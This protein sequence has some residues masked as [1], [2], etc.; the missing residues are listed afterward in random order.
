MLICPG[1]SGKYQ[2]RMRKVT[3]P[4]ISRDTC[5]TLFRNTRLGFGF[6]LDESF[7]CA[8]GQENLDTCTGDGGGPL[9]CRTPSGTYV[10]AG[11]TSWGIGCGGKDVPGAYVNVGLFSS[12]ISSNIIE[13]N[14]DTIPK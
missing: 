10:Q 13:L 3:L 9:A 2:T 1:P 7:I 11:I 5:Q 6:Q 8:G 14:R 12:W 4:V